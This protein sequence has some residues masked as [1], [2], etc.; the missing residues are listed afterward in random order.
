MVRSKLDS[1]NSLRRLRNPAFKGFVFTTVVISL[2]T[3]SALGMINRA[4]YVKP[5]SWELV[6]GSP[7]FPFNSPSFNNILYFPVLRVLIPGDPTSNPFQRLAS[8]HPEG[9]PLVWAFLIPL[10]P[11]SHH[12]V[13]VPSCIILCKTCL[14]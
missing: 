2:D 4:P 1:W 12:T 14:W 8:W 10:P 3:S 13:S 11:F 6:F 5:E 9:R 7:S